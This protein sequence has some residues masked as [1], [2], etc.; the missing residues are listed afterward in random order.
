MARKA[1][2]SFEYKS[3][4][5]RASQVRNM[6]AIEGNTPVS[7]NDW[8]AVTKGG[9]PAIEKWIADQMTGKSCTIVLIGNSTAG[10][11]WINYEIA[12]T[13]NDKKGVLGVYIHGLKDRHENQ[14]FK[15]SNPFDHITVGQQK[16][17]SIAKA[18]DPPYTPSTDVYK[19]IKDNLLSWVETAISI[20]E[21][22]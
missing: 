12:K 17:S 14:S 18:Y 20:R 15:G 1:F 19:Y 7:D 13:W 11:K 10:R 5:W 21:N 9:D 3:D 4:N 8:E 22:N 16:L 2:Y 6:G